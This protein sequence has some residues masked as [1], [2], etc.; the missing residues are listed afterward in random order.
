[1]YLRAARCV[2][3]DQWMA[4]QGTSKQGDCGLGNVL[5]EGPHPGAKAGTQHQGRYVEQ[6]LLG[7]VHLGSVWCGVR[8]NM[9]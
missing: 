9:A 6:W 7:V 1:M 4:E 5:G 3:V 2:E 8:L